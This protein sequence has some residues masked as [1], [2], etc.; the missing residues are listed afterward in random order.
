MTKLELVNLL[1]KLTS[2]RT[3]PE[4]CDQ[5][6]IRSVHPD[7]VSRNKFRWPF[8]GQWAEASGPFRSDNERGCPLEHGDG[9][10]VA[11]SWRGM[12]SGGIPAITL[13]LVAFAGGDVLGSEPH[14]IRLRKAYVDEVIDGARLLREHGRN[15]NLGSANL[16]GAYLRRAHLEGA[17][18]EGANLRRADLRRADLRG[19]LEGAYLEGADLSGADLSGAYLR[20]ANL[21]GANLRGA[22][23]RA[24]YL[25]GAY[26]EGADLRRADL[27][28]AALSGADL[29]GALM[30]E[31]Y[32]NG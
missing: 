23:L 17:Y 28:G 25:E 13:L 18:L 32:N 12:A 30:T 11:T 20:G 5:W 7:F 29:E 19:D 31:G 21:R 15:A 14:K 22:A 8:P 24:A 3:L 6:G 26:L 16:D 2:D 1:D 4:G 27:R 10:C 9:I